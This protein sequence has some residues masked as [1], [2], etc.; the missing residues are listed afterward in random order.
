MSWAETQIYDIKLFVRK[1]RQKANI[2]FPLY[3]CGGGA[4]QSQILLPHSFSLA[5][6]LSKA[7]KKH[8]S[9]RSTVLCLLQLQ[10]RDLQT[11]WKQLI[12]HLKKG[13]HKKQIYPKAQ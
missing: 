5:K 6:A 12:N 10:K 2:Y 1:L 13:P 9:H 3:H 8:L 7:G 4:N 11:N